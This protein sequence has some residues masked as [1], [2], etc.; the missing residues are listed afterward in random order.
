MNINLEINT[1]VVGDIIEQKLTAEIGLQDP[2]VHTWIADTRNSAVREALRELGWASPEDVHAM[3][4]KSEGL[5][6]SLECRNS[7]LENDRHHYKKLSEGYMDCINEL[8]EKLEDAEST[9]VIVDY[10]VRGPVETGDMLFVCG[11]EG[12][13]E[14]DGL[15]SKV[16]ELEAEVASANGLIEALEA[17]NAEL[18]NELKTTKDRFESCERNRQNH[19]RA[20]ER[21]YDRWK[22]QTKVISSLKGQLARIR[23][24][25][26]ITP[27]PIV[28]NRSFRR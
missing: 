20:S 4:A 3:K 15:R 13:R 7:D 18:Q 24:A 9:Q 1:T 12:I 6:N 17:S 23:R 11:V 26:G 10:E 14:W 22:A 19:K 25:C 2:S 27:P 5:L 8:R 21:Y 16:E 28:R